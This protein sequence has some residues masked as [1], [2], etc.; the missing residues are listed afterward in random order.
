MSGHLKLEEGKEKPENGEKIKHVAK[1]ET[2][3]NA[4]ERDN[5]KII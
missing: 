4:P 1:R 2:E 3:K 5:L